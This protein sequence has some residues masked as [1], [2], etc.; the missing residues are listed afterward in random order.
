MQ[1]ETR[2]IIDKKLK[3]IQIKMRRRIEKCRRTRKN[4]EKVEKLKAYL[5]CSLYIF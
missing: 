1:R 4:M 3:R 2:I 5:L